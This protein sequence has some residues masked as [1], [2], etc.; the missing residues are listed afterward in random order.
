MDFS[1]IALGMTDFRKT[2]GTWWMH[3]KC[4]NGLTFHLA[5]GVSGSHEAALDNVGDPDWLPLPGRVPGS[6]G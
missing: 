5:L 4:N 3:K 2:G 1:L 6:L